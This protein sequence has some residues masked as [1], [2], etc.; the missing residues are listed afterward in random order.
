MSFIQDYKFVKGNNK[1]LIFILFFRL[2]SFFGKG[3]IFLKIIGL[4]IRIIYL[5]FVQWILGIDIPDKTTIG[6]GFNVWHGQGLI[7]HPD[8]KIGD[9][10]TIRHNTTIGQKRPNEAPPRI[11]NNV[12]ISAHV[13]IIGNITIGDNV[14]IGAFTLVNKDIPEGSIVYGNPMKLNSLKKR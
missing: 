1:G 5:V 9:H 12:D 6:K 14:T 8:C 7:I 4:P 10:V 3:N 11:G 13:M 2:S